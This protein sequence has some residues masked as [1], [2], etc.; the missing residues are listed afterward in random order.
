MAICRAAPQGLHDD[1]NLGRIEVDSVKFSGDAF[2]DIDDYVV[3][4]RLVQV[5]PPQHKPDNISV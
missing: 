4:L 2:K 1:L 3:A 5:Q